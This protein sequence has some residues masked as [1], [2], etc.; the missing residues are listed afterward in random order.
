[1]TDAVCR[2]AHAKILSLDA[3]ARESEALRAHGKRVVLCHGTFD[4]IHAGHIRHLQRARELGDVLFVT[5]T[6]DAFVNK[7]PGRPAFPEALRAETLAALACVD[8]VAVSRHE[9]AIDVIKALHP[10]VYAKGS[11]Y[12]AH[13]DDVTG[14]ITREVQA[15]ERAGGAVVYTDDITFSSSRLLNEHFGLFSPE[16]ESY[17]RDFSKRYAARD[18]VA[19]LKSLRDLEVLVVGEAIVDEYHYT[20]TLGKVGKGHAMA[21]KHGSEERFAG[22]ALAVA[23][24]VAG[25]GHRVTILSTLGEKNSHEDFI[26]SKLRSN[27]TPVFHHRDD[28][29]T[30]VKRRYVDFEMDKLFE[31]YFFEDRP[32]SPGLEAE[33]CAY[34]DKAA[35]DF[36]LVIVPDYG[37]GFI[38]PRM[39]ACLTERSRFLAVNT[40][41][42]S[43]NRGHHVVTRYP[44]ADFVALNEEELRLAA[45][46]RHDSIEAVCSIVERLIRCNTLAVTRGTRGLVLRDCARGTSDTVPALSTAVVDR[47]GAGDA[48][49]ALASLCLAKRLPPE[50][51]AFVGS[52]AAAIDVQIVCNRI[53]VEPVVLFKYVTTLLKWG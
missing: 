21:V 45:H 53:P 39:I 1:M 7:G 8:F 6:A 41:V 12:K 25:F 38:T 34:L 13:S 37:N 30:I 5:V 26:L 29:P 50:V 10:H 11:D 24:H 32:V 22:G 35:A 44:R 3:L 47:V 20:T 49:L 14:N 48:F 46:S 43:G 19:M 15:I 52:A 27:V 16:A 28:A 36:D 31:V 42:N 23:N 18:V 17:L 40:Q 9:T 33:I 4:L 51:A 2:D